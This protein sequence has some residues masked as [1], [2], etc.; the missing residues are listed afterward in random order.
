M[1]ALG[2]WRGVEGDHEGRPFDGWPA[3]ACVGPINALGY[4]LLRP[5]QAEQAGQEDE[6]RRQRAHKAVI[7]VRSSTQATCEPRSA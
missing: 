7:S 2:G 4:G 3:N 5:A 6:G 1:V